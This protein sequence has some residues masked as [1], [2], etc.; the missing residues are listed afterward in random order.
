LL[1]LSSINHGLLLP[2]L[3]QCIDDQG[4]P[5]LEPARKGRETEEFRNARTDIPTVVEAIRQYWMPIRY[6]TAG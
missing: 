2:I 1:D 3:L 5:L 4:H 6:A